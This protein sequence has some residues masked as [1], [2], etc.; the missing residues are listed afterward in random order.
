MAITIRTVILLASLSPA[1][2]LGLLQFTGIFALSIKP[3]LDLPSQTREVALS[4]A[5]LQLDMAREG[6]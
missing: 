5:V 6:S 4:L 1:A 2:F 3:M